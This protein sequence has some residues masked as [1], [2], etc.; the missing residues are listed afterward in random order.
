LR[1]FAAIGGFLPQYLVAV[2]R[3][4]Y[5]EKMLKSEYYDSLRSQAQ[6]EEYRE[7]HS[8]ARLDMVFKE[9]LSV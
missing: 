5:P 9:M 1:Y 2:E 6:W 7:A 4:A 8:V 3:S